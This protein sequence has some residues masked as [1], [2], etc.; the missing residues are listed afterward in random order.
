M[1]LRPFASEQEYS[2]LKEQLHVEPNDYW[3]AW[4]HPRAKTKKDFEETGMLN[5]DKYST[6][7]VER[8]DTNELVGLEEYGGTASGRCNAWIGTFISREHWHNGFGIEAKQLCLCHIF[9]NFQVPRV[10]ADTLENHQRAAR[11]LHL[12]GMKFEGRAKKYHYMDGHYYDIV[13]YRIFREEWEQQPFRHGV[14]RGL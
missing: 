9:E 6:F 2:D 7:A 3:G 5:A 11:G 13:C 1:R 4:W 12:C 14:K 10:E 8:L